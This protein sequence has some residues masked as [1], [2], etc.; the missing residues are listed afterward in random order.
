[1]ADSFFLTGHTGFLGK[2]V[3]G[4]LEASGVKTDT[5]E[6]V[7]GGPVD[8]TK[9]FEFSPGYHADVIVH[10]AGKAHMEPKTKEEEEVFYNVN[11]NGTKHLA[12][13]LVKLALKPSAFVFI[14]TVAVYGLDAG[15]MITEDHPL[16]G[17]TPY[18]K[19]KIM[20][21]EWLTQWAAD[22]D[23]VLTI[24]RLPLV[25]GIR[26]PGNLGA[27]ISGIKTGKYL[28]IGKADARKSIIWAED[29]ARVIPQL[30]AI[31]GT[32]NITD[33]YHATFKELETVISRKLN[34]KQPLAIPMFMAKLMGLAGDM[35]GKKAPINTNK[36][37]KITSTLTFDDSKLHKALQWQPSQVLT[38][39]NDTL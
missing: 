12:E 27:M 1:M 28:S 22:N 36:I 17:S 16:N 21:E 35:L 29:I 31:G 37:K 32:Y 13:A 24:L 25:A 4:Y 38:K 11:Y 23:I 14:S 7:L 3:A 9:P 39:L 18:A 30:S 19:S 15:D 33:G 6:T 20:A 26:P 5:F 8:I 34:K 10:I 2:V